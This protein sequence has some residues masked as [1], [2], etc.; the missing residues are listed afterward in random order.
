MVGFGS[1][2]VSLNSG[3]TVHYITAL[4]EFAFAIVACIFATAGPIQTV[5]CMHTIIITCNWAACPFCPTLFVKI[6]IKYCYF[7]EL[8]LQRKIKTGIKGS[9]PNRLRHAKYQNGV[10]SSTHLALATQ[11]TSIDLIML[12]LFRNGCHS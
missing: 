8:A 4:S 1:S 11:K 7:P 12:Y 2:F 10:F 5:Q 3:I 9:H 6:Y